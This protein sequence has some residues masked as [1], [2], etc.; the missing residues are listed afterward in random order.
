MMGGQGSQFKTIESW[1]NPPFLDESAPDS[2]RY[3]WSK[4]RRM[5]KALP[6]GKNGKGWATVLLLEAVR[7][8]IFLIYLTQ[9]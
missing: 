1:T 3:K 2:S 6:R 9:D 4:I 5:A 8:F 7:T